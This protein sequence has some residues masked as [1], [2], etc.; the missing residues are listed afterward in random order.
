MSICIYMYIFICVCVCMCAC[1]LGACEDQKRAL[2]PLELE[3]HMAMCSHITENQTQV[4]C[5]N[6]K[7]S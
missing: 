4:L 7:C 6:S 5:K 1:M 3:L 2:D